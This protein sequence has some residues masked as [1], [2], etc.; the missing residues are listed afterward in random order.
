MFKEIAHKI[1]IDKAIAY[2]TG[3]Y[4]VQ[5]ITGLGSIVFIA[6]FLSLEE[7]GYYF[8]FGSIL[9]LQVFFELGLTGIMTQFVAHEV[10]HLKLNHEGFYEGESL[11]KSRLA[12]LLKFCL[13]WYS[14]LSVLI[15]VF[16]LI[17]G[18]FF[19]SNYGK[20]HVEVEWLAPWII[21]CFGASI[22]LFISPFNSILTGAGF[23]KDINRI[24]FW[25]Q[26]IKPT[27]I[28]AGLIAGMKLY[29]VGIGYIISLV[30]WFVFTYKN[31][32]LRIL[33]NL[34]K[35]EIKERVNYIK[36]I[37]PYQWRIA[38][39]WISG[40][41]IFQLFNPV[42]FATEGAVV[43]GQMGM[44]LTVLT[45]IQS[46]SFSWINT[47]IPV[48]S[49]YIAQKEYEQLD[50]Q[51][52]TTVKQM[53]SVCLFLLL[54]FGLVVYLIDV[55]QIQ[56][57]GNLLRYRFL[58]YIP[59]ILMMIPIYSHQFVNS[60]ATYLR[61]HKKEPFLIFSVVFGVACCCS[62]LGLGKVYGLIGITLGYCI[63]NLSLFPWAYSIYRNKKREWHEES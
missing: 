47:K 38:L 55:T 23:V 8:T 36:E 1:G 27:F 35:E 48:F 53:T 42:L 51:F 58:P 12:S 26:I 10:S 28:W 32:L 44:T 7:Q 60:W 56:Y 15:L 17:F 54:S 24:V 43:A 14:I 49:G 25:Q 29:V 63:I 41:F 2:S 3:A 21:I 9:S 30:I 52:R 16:L 4:A 57:K 31:K 50:T 62:T 13:K 6:T 20:E 34:Y 39:S 46:L 45:S 59:M 11:Y 33:V 5:A 61:C 37:F 22:N 18:Y 40:Y 19:F